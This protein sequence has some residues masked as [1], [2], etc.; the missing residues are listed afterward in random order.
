MTN[1]DDT[2][3][4]PS[5]SAEQGLVAA[6]TEEAQR[7][8]RI[9]ANH[10]NPGGPVQ[11][12]IQRESAGWSAAAEIAAPYEARRIAAEAHIARCGCEPPMCLLCGNREP[13]G[14]HAPGPDGQPDPTAGLVCT[15][16]PTYEQAMRAK[17]KAERRVQ[18]LEAAIQTAIA[19]MEMTSS[20]PD[21]YHKVMMKPLREALLPA[22]TDA[23][24][25]Q[26]A[27]GETV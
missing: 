21:T 14:L 11:A 25:E 18:T 4:P 24:T 6:L 26:G 23:G 19:Y 7:L 2:T 12:S 1:A 5:E 3:P 22:V 9:A 8:A 16:E 20:D 27:E 17:L 10:C 15:F 13:C